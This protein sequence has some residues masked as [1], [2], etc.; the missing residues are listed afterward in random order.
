MLRL[1]VLVLVVRS[2][3]RGSR[4]AFYGDTDVPV[5]KVDPDSPE[6]A[7]I[8]QQ[9]SALFR[10]GGAGPDSSSPPP[11]AGFAAIN[12]V[13]MTVRGQADSSPPAYTTP[14]VL[15]INTDLELEHGRPSKVRVPQGELLLMYIPQIRGPTGL[16]S[17][18]VSHDQLRELLTETDSP[19]SLVMLP[20]GGLLLMS[21]SPYTDTEPRSDQH[22]SII[23]QRICNTVV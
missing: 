11:A 5:I 16:A 21:L 19:S 2:D 18:E 10:E 22:S 1:L 14:F 9:I 4:Q 17:V 15:N 6:G 20:S 7:K 23:Q 8:A 3:L 12:R 13:D